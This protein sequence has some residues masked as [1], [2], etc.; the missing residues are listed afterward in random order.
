MLSLLEGFNVKV[1]TTV[2][3]TSSNF[4][5]VVSVTWGDEDEDHYEASRDKFIKCKVYLLAKGCKTCMYRCILEI[6]NNIENENARKFREE[7]QIC[8]NI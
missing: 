7:V 3:P 2:D 1:N 6:F 8:L 5:A 4:T